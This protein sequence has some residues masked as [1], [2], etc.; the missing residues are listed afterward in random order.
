MVSPTLRVIIENNGGVDC[1][2]SSK[3]SEEKEIK[4]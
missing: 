1:Y 4:E 2:E 3:L